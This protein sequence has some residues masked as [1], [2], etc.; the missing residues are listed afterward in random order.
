MLMTQDTQS[1]S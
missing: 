1:L